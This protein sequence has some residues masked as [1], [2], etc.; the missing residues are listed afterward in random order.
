MNYVAV[1]CSENPVS[2][3]MVPVILRAKQI[4][5]DR[6]N[7]INASRPDSD[8]IFCNVHAAA[9]GVNVVAHVPQRNISS[10][11][12]VDSLKQAMTEGWPGADRVLQPPRR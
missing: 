11:T 9:N 4:L 12:Y 5:I 3:S 2:S 7:T 6:A 10:L 1:H 8:G